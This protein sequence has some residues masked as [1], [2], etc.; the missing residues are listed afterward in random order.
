MY[1]SFFLREK[2]RPLSNFEWRH[3]LNLI[4]TKHI[5][6]NKSLLRDILLKYVRS[7]FIDKTHKRTY[8]CK[9]IH[10]VPTQ[11]S[12]RER[13]L[14]FFYQRFIFTNGDEEAVQEE[15]ISGNWGFLNCESLKL[16]PKEEKV[17]RNECPQVQLIFLKEDWE[18]DP[19]AF[20]NTQRCSGRSQ[21]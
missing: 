13:L 12:N 9:H 14:L 16:N 19:P 10:T 21:G 8:K 6:L 5:Y 3:L 20:C 17:P 1:I 2:L 7:N 11:R 4:I 18:E 15:E